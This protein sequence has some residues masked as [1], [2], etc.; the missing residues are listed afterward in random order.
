MIVFISNYFNHHQLPISKELYVLTN[1]NYRFIEL[2]KI[3][4]SF[5]KS[6][7]PTC[8][9]YPLL[10]Q[11]W[12]SA[13]NMEKAKQLVIDAHTVIYG[14]LNNYS[15]I[16]ERLNKNKLTFECGER[17]F[18]RGLLNLLSPRLL[19]SQFLYHTKF[20]HRPLFHLNASAYAA[21]DLIKLRSF[22]GKCFKWGYF[23]QVPELNI[24]NIILD[25]RGSNNH[26][27]L[28]WVARFINWKH[29]EI[30]IKV[31]L[32]LKKANLNFEINMYG[33]GELITDIERMIQKLDLRDCVYLKGSLANAEILKEMRK[34]DAFLMT[35]DRREG[36]GAVVN[37]AMSNGCPVIGNNAVGAI[38]YLIKDGENGMIYHGNDENQIFDKIKQLYFSPDF[39]FYLAK[40]AYR[41]MTDM[42]SPEIAAK[43]LLI[44]IENLSNN[45][46]SEISEGPCSLA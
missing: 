4:S 37:E 7:Y 25:R 32:L 44:L 14:N 20:Y 15:W 34:H 43:N 26:L 1:G 19:K 11:A 6:G 13:D 27:K 23:T 42:W 2:E 17:W 31:A 10:I 21:K 16:I 9:K 36:W 35:S 8:D 24:N 3:P 5:Q 22:K 12:K 30:P 45:K 18:K 40:N 38:P 41:T 39:R 29:P 28:M 46:S 33:R